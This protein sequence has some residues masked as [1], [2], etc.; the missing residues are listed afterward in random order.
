MSNLP[1]GYA[2]I[3]ASVRYDIRLCSS[4]KLFYGEVVALASKTGECFAGYDYFSKV[5]NTSGRSVKRWIDELVETGHVEGEIGALKPTIPF[6]EMVKD[7]KGTLP[8]RQ[9]PF[10]AKHDYD[11]WQYKS[12]VYLLKGFQKAYGDDLFYSIKRSLKKPE[13]KEKMLNEWASILQTTYEQDFKEGMGRSF[14]DFGRFVKFLVDPSNW[15]IQ[16]KA[17]RSISKGMRSRR[18]GEPSKMDKLIDNWIE[19]ESRREKLDNQ[20]KR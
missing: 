5:F 12:A 14:Q 8:K 18:N 13:V 2:I 10:E 17:L 11:S 6:K 19:E 16:N 9:K 20:Y 3:P 1:T 15:W 7:L 4:A